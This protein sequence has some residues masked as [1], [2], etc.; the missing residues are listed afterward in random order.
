[1]EKKTRNRARR[2]EN[3]RGG[4]G[5]DSAWIWGVHAALAALENPQ[6]QVLEIH[7]TRNAAA[8]EFAA[9][10]ERAEIIDPKALTALLPPGAVHQGVA[11]KAKQPESVSIEDLIAPAE[12]LLVMLDGV[13]DPRNAGAIYRSAAAFGAKGIIMQDRKA[14]PLSG[15]LAKTAVGAAEMVPT[16]RV[17]NLSRALGE[18]TK[19]GWRAIGLAGEAEATLSESFAGEEAV[20]LVLG[21]EDK[22]LRPSVAEACDLVARIPM[23][24]AVES[25]NVSTAA[26][27]AIYEW[28][29]SRL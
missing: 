8:G 20:I 21:A 16:A 6:R 22:G 24:G 14:P 26:S 17:V 2:S 15:G 29:R 5:D 12:G 19:R 7:L 4:A 1:M 23:S 10:A 18:F 11:L 13:T 27:V 9:Y 3:R 25:L 28:A